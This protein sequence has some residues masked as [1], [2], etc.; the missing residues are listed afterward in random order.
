MKKF[1]SLLGVMLAITVNA[2]TNTV[3]DVSTNLP[4]APPSIPEIPGK[5]IDFLSVTASNWYVAPYGIYSSDT[6]SF[7]AG[8]GAGYSITPNVVT[9]MRIDYLNDEIWMPSGSLQLQAPIRLL[10][11]LQV[12]P[13]AFGGIATPLSGR[14]DDNRTA[15]GIAGAGFG[16]RFNDHLG[17]IYD[18]EYWSNFSGP[19]HRFGVFWKF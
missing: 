15:A 11:K 9:V 19:Q 14:G 6:E 13:F 3:P 2:Q 18:V 8:I 5:I 10:N 7:G 12:T 1:L 17:L 16:A 4:P